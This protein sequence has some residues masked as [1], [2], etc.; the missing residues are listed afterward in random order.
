MT[1]AN[2]RPRIVDVAFWCWVAAAFLLILFGVL[3]VTATAPVFFRAAGGVFTIA[4]LALAYLAGRTRRRNSRFRWAA[5]AL[6]LTL[7][8]LLILFDILLRG[9]VWLLIVILLLIGAFAATRDTA[10]AWFDAVASGSDG[11]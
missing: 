5:V 9:L 3:L 10:S 4:G 8:V 2:P 6:A 1:S 7:V 11:D